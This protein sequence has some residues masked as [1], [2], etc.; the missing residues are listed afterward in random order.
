VPANTLAEQSVSYYREVIERGVPISRG[1][2]F[3]ESDGTKVLY[4]VVILP[5]SDDGATISGLL[6][7][8]NCRVPAEAA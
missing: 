6:G 4:R 1:G 5:M 2:E 7:A 8:A 3:T